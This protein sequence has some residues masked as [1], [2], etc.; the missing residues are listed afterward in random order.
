MRQASRAVEERTLAKSVCVGW[1]EAQQGNSAAKQMFRQVQ[2]KRG[3]DTSA[4]GIGWQWVAGEKNPWIKVAGT[5][6]PLYYK[7]RPAERAS[8]QALSLLE[9]DDGPDTPSDSEEERRSK[10]EE[11]HG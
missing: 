3:C 4:P 2:G 1:I 11:R 8:W 10:Y 9:M 7:F 6:E 5:W